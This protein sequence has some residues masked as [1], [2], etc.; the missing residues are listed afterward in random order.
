MRLHLPLYALLLALFTL[1]ACTKDT[2][3]VIELG[4][5][6]SDET[7]TA[8]FTGTITATDGT[9]LSGV[10]VAAGATSAVTDADGAYTLAGATVV[11]DRAH[12]T[13]RGEGYVNG[14]R[15]LL[16]DG[17]STHQVDVELL[18][19]TDAQAISA[20]SA[21][22]VE[23]GTTGASVA[24]PAA[25]FATADGAPAPGRVNVV[26]HYLPGDAESS[27]RRMPGDLRGTN[28]EGQVTTLTPLG[29]ISTV[30]R[31]DS[32]N[33]LR[34]AKGKTAT[35]TI[36][37]PAAARATAPAT[38]PLYY[39]DEASAL[40]VAEGQAT[41]TD[42]GYV[43][44]VSHF[45]FWAAMLGRTG[46]KLCGQVLAQDQDGNT[47]PFANRRVFA[48]ADGF[49]NAAVGTDAEGRFCGI[50]PA[51][52]TVTLVTATGCDGVVEIATVP[53]SSSNVALGAITFTPSGPA[54]VTLRGRIVCSDGE[55]RV[56]RVRLT[57]SDGEFTA[58]AVGPN[59]AFRARVD[60]CGTDS[61]RVA[62][63]YVDPASGE[64]VTLTRG[65]ARGADHDFGNIEACRAKGP[66]A[67]LERNSFSAT[68]GRD[69]LGARRRDILITADATGFT[70]VDT[71]TGGGVVYLRALTRAG[72]FLKVGRYPL[73]NGAVYNPR[74]INRTP[75]VSLEGAALNVTSVV[76]ATATT[77]MVG[78]GADRPVRLA[79]R[80]RQGRRGNH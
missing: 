22:D 5:R 68:I 8:T 46:I 59:G 75:R 28:A 15:T 45:T 44:E 70:V 54:Q 18:S 41:L 1:G 77:P 16:V 17:G 58:A 23:I 10:I 11:A 73:A 60:N 35:L 49:P 64:T 48:R 14:S 3:E 4:P 26:A 53:P 65:V 21:S 62:I 51:E 74:G 34:L 76:P 32:G 78:P 31:D 69:T 67:S 56:V 55:R 40:W 80:R 61:L 29:M 42:A 25:A 13:V 9:G 19:L 57:G 24:F 39:F 52:T 37:V 12:L 79:R 20:A 47:T 38:A 27:L 2:T 72:D 43:G 6:L 36:P 66:A 33:A 30:L 50:V 71:T 7:V 63:S